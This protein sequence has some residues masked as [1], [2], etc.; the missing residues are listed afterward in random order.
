MAHIANKVD[1][2]DKKLFEVFTGQRYKID[3]FQREYRWQ[4]VHIE[5]LISDLTTEFL[6]SYT[7]GDSI[8]KS[9]QYDC[10]YMGPIVLCQDGK[11]DLSIV[12]GQQRLTS[13]TL[14]LIYIHHLQKQLG[15]DDESSADIMPLLYVKR[16]GKKTFVLNIESRNSIIEKLIGSPSE[17]I[18]ETSTLDMSE[19]NQNIIHRYD[20]ICSL[21]PIELKNR[22]SLPVFTEWLLHNIVMV[23][24]RAYSIENAYTIF[25][26]M[27]NRGLTLN[28]TEILKGYLLTKIV[29]NH[30]ENEEKEEEAN[31]FWTDRILKLKTETKYEESE[32]DFFRA[33]LRA[34]YA[35]TQRAKKVGSENEDFELIGTQFHS[36]VKNNSKTMGLVK[37]ED[38]YFFIRSD[39]DFFSSIYLNLYYYMHNYEHKYKNLF[40]NA[41]YS[42]ADSLTFPLLLSPITKIDFEDELND[43]INIVSTFIDCYTNI[44]MLQNRSITQSSIRNNIYDIVRKIR[45]SNISHLYSLLLDEYNKVVSYSEVFPSFQQMNNYGYY[46]YIYARILFYIDDQQD[47]NSLLRSRKHDSYIL[48]RIFTI[49][50][51]GKEYDEPTADAYYNSVANYTLLRRTFLSQYLECSSIKEKI[52][53]LNE[54][55]KIFHF[56]SESGS[57]IKYITKHEELLRDCVKEIWSFSREQY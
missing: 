7:S 56:E 40:L 31:S 34:K 45:N 21:F 47:F 51:I 5:S 50:D 52:D 12:D 9:S 22:E 23:E 24:V 35:E 19:S 20:D 17:I 10:Y 46:H 2:E 36:W 33:W 27:N 18:S 54:H 13:F 6:K 30:P 48:L 25:E 32:L 55:H 44:R 11:G 28:P 53:F 8:E 41:H 14:L 1:A 43:K 39:F 16:G 49:D 3:A 29:D 15:L 42:I 37:P 4:R 26:T 38:F 57:A